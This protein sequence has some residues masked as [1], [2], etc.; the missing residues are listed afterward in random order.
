MADGMQPSK[1]IR[2]NTKIN[3]S[4]YPILIGKNI[5]KSLP[6]EIL[7]FTKS[8]KVLILCDKI[9][10]KNTL[11]L[12]KS[13]MK[14]KYDMDIKLIT[15]GKK[16][17]NINN[18]IR[19]LSF[20]EKNRFSKDSTLVALGGG[21]IGDL[22]GFVAS[23]YY[24][25]MNLVLIPSTLTAQIDSSYGGKV[26]VNFNNNVNAIG[27]YFHPKLVIC[28]Y[29][30]IQSLPLREF[31][32]G[33]SEVVKSALISSK[34]DCNFLLNN[35]E[36][37]KK[38]NLSIISKMISRI[39]KI[40]LGIVK[41]DVRENNVRMFLNYGHT[42][43]QS[44]EASTNLNLEIY[45]HGEAVSLGMI[46]AAKLSDLVFPKKKPIFDYHLKILK[47][48]NLPIKI[49]KKIN[50]NNLKYKIFKN[51][52]RDKKV[53][54]QGL[55]FVLLNGLGKPRIVAKI[56]ENKIKNSISHIF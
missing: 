13:S 21:T 16:S 20:L 19:V 12:I 22:G 28:D 54:F 24:R 30:F 40:K 37:I 31:N 45:R 7:K 33:M 9:F 1:L 10:K 42:V 52:F 3:S 56:K 11:R 48:F 53:N 23:V 29:S 32:S 50:K 6:K 43:G 49:S 51:L 55:R 36:K 15:P 27:N 35:S 41:K 5:I 4:S 14:N 17:K 8:K 47:N 46:V 38:R 39:I 25:G 44:I 34:S 18:A 26:A 2:L